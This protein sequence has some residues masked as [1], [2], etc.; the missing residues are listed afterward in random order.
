MLCVIITLA[1]IVEFNLS[2][3][4]AVSRGHPVYERSP[5]PAIEMIA[6]RSYPPNDFSKSIVQRYSS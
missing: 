2:G 6:N 5:T 4:N 3:Y 1:F